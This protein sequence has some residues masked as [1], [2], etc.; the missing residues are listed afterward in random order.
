MAVRKVKVKEGEKLTP[1]NI[2]KVIGLLETE[3]PISKKDA[4]EILNISYNTARLAKIIEQ[5]K[6]AKIL[7]EKRRAANRGKPAAPHE[8]QNVIQGYLDGDSFTDIADQIYRP[9]SF[10][11]KIIEDVG[12]P[13]RAGDG[14]FRPDMLPERCIS[15]TFRIGEV[16]WSSRH[17]AMAII[18]KEYL[19]DDTTQYQIYVIEPIEEPS[20]FFPQYQDY[21]GFYATI[22]FYDLGKLEHL[23]EYGIDVCKPYRATFGNWLEGR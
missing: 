1:S 14:Y 3:K 9:V 12:V 18:R 10:V 6:E 13:G 2:E 16:V 8:I 15:E 21:G 5:F 23:K 22:A 4:C 17:N 19:K 20:P 11:K 7:D